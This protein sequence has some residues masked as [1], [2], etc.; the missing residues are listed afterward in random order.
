[1]SRNDSLKRFDLEPSCLCNRTLIMR[2]PFRS[3]HHAHP[4]STNL[5]VSRFSDATSRV[6]YSA[7]LPSNIISFG[8]NLAFTW[9]GP[10]FVLNVIS[11]SPA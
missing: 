10:I 6:A 1:M 4:I 3:Q 2:H 5:K 8:T 11:L 9:R 7:S